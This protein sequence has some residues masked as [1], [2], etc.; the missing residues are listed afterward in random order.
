MER[1]SPASRRDCRS[2]RSS[3]TATPPKKNVV[4]VQRSVLKISTTELTTGWLSA[5]A[6]QIL[7]DETALV[8]GTRLPILHVGSSA[9][10]QNVLAVGFNAASELS[11]AGVLPASALDNL[12]TE[13]SLV[14][15]FGPENSP[16]YLI[17][18]GHGALRGTIYGVYRFLEAALGLRFLTPNVT[19]TTVW[20]KQS[21]PKL[22]G[23]M[24]RNITSDGSS[25]HSCRFVP[26]LEMRDM[27]S[28]D[29]TFIIR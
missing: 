20:S 16:S 19:T 13:G 17:T 23:H 12:G 11:E 18:G 28:I 6:A 3:C 25:N 8:A 15:G 27:V 14:Y 21:D 29:D 1:S 10:V 5:D 7:R 24:F 9:P 2:T 26:V 22:P 4:S